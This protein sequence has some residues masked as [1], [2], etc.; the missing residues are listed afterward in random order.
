[1][2]KEGNGEK[3]AKVSVFPPSMFTDLEDLESRERFK[4]LV[5]FQYGFSDEQLDR[6]IEMLRRQE[7]WNAE[8]DF[9]LVEITDLDHEYFGRIGQLH[10]V[11]NGHFVGNTPLYELDSEELRK[12]QANIEHKLALVVKADLFLVELAEDGG[13]YTLL[14]KFELE[15]KRIEVEEEGGGVGVLL[16][17]RQNEG[18]RLPVGFYTAKFGDEIVEVEDWLMMQEPTW[19]FRRA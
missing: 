13:Q 3:P 7:R 14:N 6:D 15:N 9:N 8:V 19:K 1:M 11:M 17:W 10:Y 18:E 5:K 4:A 16:G 2:R 12:S